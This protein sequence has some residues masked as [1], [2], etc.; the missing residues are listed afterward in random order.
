MGP[1]LKWIHGVLS[2]A[3]MAA[4]GVLW[5][6]FDLFHYVCSST[7]QPRWRLLVMGSCCADVVGIRCGCGWILGVLNVAVMAAWGVLWLSLIY[8]ITYVAQPTNC[9]SGFARH[10]EMPCKLSL[11]LCVHE[12]NAAC[13]QVL[14]YW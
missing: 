14:Q 13:P 11:N 6:V 8:F 4:L 10:W 7:N 5:D 2:V 3:V 12:S 9:T 1:H